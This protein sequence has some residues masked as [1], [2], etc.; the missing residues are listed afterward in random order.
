MTTTVHITNKD[1]G[2]QRRKRC[3]YRIFYIKWLFEDTL[4]TLEDNTEKVNNFG[5]VSKSVTNTS[6]L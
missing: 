5:E 4:D 3:T 1:G 6:G 2:K